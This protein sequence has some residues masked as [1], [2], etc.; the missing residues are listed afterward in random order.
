M[1]IRIAGIITLGIVALGALVFA[2]FWMDRKAKQDLEDRKQ[3][4]VEKDHAD[5]FTLNLFN[6]ILEDDQLRNEQLVAT[7]ARKD[8][9]IEALNRKIQ[10]MRDI[11]NK[12]KLADL[13][14]SVEEEE[15]A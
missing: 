5:N 1:A 6:M 13:F 9:T 12:C 2:W 14:Q 11:A 4:L 3:R 10:K 7:N 8:E 15:N